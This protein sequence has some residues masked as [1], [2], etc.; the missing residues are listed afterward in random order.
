MK[1]SIAGAIAAKSALRSRR[2][3]SRCSRSD[4]Q[5]NVARGNRLLNGSTQ[6][7]AG[8]YVLRLTADD[9]ESTDADDVTVVVEEA[10]GPANQPSVVNAASTE[11]HP[12]CF[13]ES[14]RIDERRW[15]IR[16][17]AAVART[18]GKAGGQ[19]RLIDALEFSKA[20]V[21]L[22][23]RTDSRRRRKSLCRAAP[24]RLLRTIP[25]SCSPP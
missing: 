25:S 10:S 19:H 5:I 2:T 6:L 18:W 9:G 14:R 16:S 7:R 4:G 11:R 17:P 15:I 13:H 23:S 21:L 20:S 1:Q 24:L 8:S 22:I 3:P 12:S